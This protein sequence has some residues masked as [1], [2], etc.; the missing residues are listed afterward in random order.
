MFVG[1]VNAGQSRLHHLPRE[2]AG[3]VAR[4]DQSEV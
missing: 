1:G 4:F 2:M 3:T